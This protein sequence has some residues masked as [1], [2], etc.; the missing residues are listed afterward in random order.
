PHTYPA[1]VL[2]LVVARAPGRAVCVDGD[3][4]VLDDGRGREW[5]GSVAGPERREVHEG[6]ERGARLAPGQRH[7]VKLARL[8][9]ASAHEGADLAPGGVERDEGGLESRT[10]IAPAQPRVAA[11]ELIEAGRH[12]VLGEALK[13][14]I[15]RGDDARARSEALLDLLADVIG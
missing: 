10:R 2:A 14:E 12:R 9:V 13:A 7:P 15:E 8:V 6:L 11:L 4:G 1:C 5:P 3:G